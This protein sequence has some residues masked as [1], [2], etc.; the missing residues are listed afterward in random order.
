MKPEA[1]KILKMIEA[2]DPADAAAMSK[3]DGLVSVLVSA[4]KSSLHPA[5]YLRRYTRSID[6]QEA[7]RRQGWLVDVYH[8]RE[9]PPTFRVLM[10]RPSGE[11]FYESVSCTEPLARLHAWVQV[12][13]MQDEVKS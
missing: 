1:Q 13:G 12:I 4:D 10:G 6:A 7:L 9:K 8:D 3:I 11:N 2:V 5:K